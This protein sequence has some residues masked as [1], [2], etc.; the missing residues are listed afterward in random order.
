M[1]GESKR[2]SIS[3]SAAGFWASAQPVELF[4]SPTQVVEMT[5]GDLNT[6]LLPLVIKA[7]S[8]R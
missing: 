7:N 1:V 5:I 3:R 4:W 6:T 2:A 8:G